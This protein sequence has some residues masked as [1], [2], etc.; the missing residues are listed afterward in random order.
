MSERT[1]EYATKRKTLKKQKAKESQSAKT[2]NKWILAGV[3]F[4]SEIVNVS[5]EMSAIDVAK[6][7]Q[8][9]YETQASSHSESQ[10]KS[11]SP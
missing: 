4:F 2:S 10:H 11:L 7:I 3:A 5:S 1:W 8:N 9:Y 6:V